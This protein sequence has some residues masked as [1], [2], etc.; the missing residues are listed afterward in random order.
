[1]RR[2]FFAN[3]SHELRTPMTVLQELS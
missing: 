3:V 2:N 1:M